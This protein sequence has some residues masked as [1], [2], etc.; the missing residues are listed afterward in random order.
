MPTMT[1]RLE[2]LRAFLVLASTSTLVCLAATGCGDSGES[3]DA[4][5]DPPGDGDGQEG[6][7]DTGDGDGSG[8]NEPAEQS[9]GTSS[10]DGDN[11][12]GDVSTADCGNQLV[13]EPCSGSASCSWS[14]E[15]HCLEG[16]CSCQSGKFVCSS[17]TSTNCNSEGA[18]C[19]ESIETQCGDPC[20][21][22]I[23]N[24]LCSSGGGPDYTNCSCT[25]GTWDCGN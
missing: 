14:D 24:C 1:S 23:H 9:G 15:E 22:T 17:Q 3:D 19:P 25:S 8:G 20:E 5:D 18:T 16:M 7:G 6:D 10:G 2:R 11:G 4:Q 13:G 12:D 21:G